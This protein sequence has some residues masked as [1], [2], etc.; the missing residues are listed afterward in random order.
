MKQYEEVINLLRSGFEQKS[1]CTIKHTGNETVKKCTFKSFCKLFEENSEKAYLY[2]GVDGRIPNYK[3]MSKEM[4]VNNCLMMAK[5]RN[6]NVAGVSVG[7]GLTDW[8]KNKIKTRQILLRTV[9]QEGK[10]PDY[11]KFQQA[12]LELELE[13][14]EEGQMGV[15]FNQMKKP[16]DIEA[17]FKKLE[18]MAGVK[19]GDKVKNAYV[20]AGLAE[21][22]PSMGSSPYDLPVSVVSNPFLDLTLTNSVK[23]AGSK[24]KVLENQAKLRKATNRAKSIFKKSQREILVF[25]KS[26]KEKNPPSADQINQMIKRIETISYDPN[27]SNNASCQGPNAFYNTDQHRFTL[28]PQIMEFPE[29]TLKAIIVHELAHSI[30][31]CIVSQPFYTIKNVKKHSGGQF[32]FLRANT[33]ESEDYIPMKEVELKHTHFVDYMDQSKARLDIMYESYDLTPLSKGVPLA[34]NPFSKSISCLSDPDAL[35]ARSSSKEEVKAELEKSLARMKAQGATDADPQ[36]VNLKKSLE[37][38]DNLYAKIG[39]CSALPGNSQLQEG[40]SDW[41]A[42]EILGSQSEKLSPKNQQRHAF[43]TFGF[44]LGMDCSLDMGSTGDKVQKFL[45]DNECVA[46]NSSLSSTLSTISR[47]LST[48]DVHNHGI[49]RVEKV[50]MSQPQLKKALGCDSSAGGKYCE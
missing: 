1:D 42:A 26:K 10:A 24:A 14:L 4:E 39:A 9:N 3:L 21:N 27:V 46:D 6:Q 30:D 50:F 5:T 34:K 15:G 43:E 33:A 11:L 19:L 25:L 20:E 23:S 28:C 37:K 32:D 2:E 31:P 44:F 40:F 12:M 48:E 49:D 38:L 22:M 18:T 13:S 45:E 8:N 36:Y 7:N 29:A 16:E 35:G 47:S 17:Q 41:L